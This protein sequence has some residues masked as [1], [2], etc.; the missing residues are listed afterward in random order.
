MKHNW[1]GDIGRLESAINLTMDDPNEV[2]L[3]LRKWKLYVASYRFAYYIWVIFTLVT[4]KLPRSRSSK[5]KFLYGF[6]KSDKC[7]I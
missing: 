2:I 7:F 5:V 3:K 1:E 4:L 6:W